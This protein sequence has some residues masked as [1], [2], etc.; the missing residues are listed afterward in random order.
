MSKIVIP[1]INTGT[2]AW[3]LSEDFK[4]SQ[5]Y[6]RLINELGIEY[7][8]AVISVRV[9]I[10]FLIEN[11]TEDTQEPSV[12]LPDVSCP[13]SSGTVCKK[14]GNQM[15]LTANGGYPCGTI[16]YSCPNCDDIDAK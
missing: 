12:V 7:D 4:Q 9:F 16:C 2:L 10:A 8:S 1:N 6:I 11:Y 13:D 15:K 5:H 3:N 14:C